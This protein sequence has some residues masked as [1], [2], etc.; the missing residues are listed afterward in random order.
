M[1]VLEQR[2]SFSVSSK[3]ERVFV[4]GKVKRTIV[5]IYTTQDMS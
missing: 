4:L 5:Y 3:N 1:G 2:H